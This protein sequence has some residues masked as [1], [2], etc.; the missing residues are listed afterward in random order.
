[1]NPPQDPID[2]DAVAVATTDGTEATR[3]LLHSPIN[4]RSTSLAILALLACLVALHLASAVFIPLLVGMMVSYALSPVVDRLERLHVPRALGAALL[5]GAVCGS[6][7]GVAYAVSDDATALIESLPEVSQKLRQTVQAQR[8]HSESAID[9]MQRA[10]TQLEQA[11]RESA[12]ASEPASAPRGVTRVTIER[13]HFDIKD[14]L[15][16]GTLG[17]AASVGQAVVVVFI[18]FFLM[19]SGNTFRRKIVH[20]AGPT[21]AQ[22]RITVEVLDEITAQIHRYLLVQ[23]VTSGFVGLSVGLAFWA[24]GLER[25]AV[26]GVVALVFDFVPYFGALATTLGAGLVAFVQFG[27]LHM[28][29][30]VAGTAMAIHTLSGNLLMPWLTSQTSRMNAV[31]VFVGVLAFGWLWG[32]WG[33]L[34]GVP[35]LAAVKAICDRVEGL[36][37]IGE[38]MGA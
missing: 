37:P 27:N 4:V 31:T 1:M 13:P 10:A 36:K 2:L 26:W 29:L 6:V 15:W 18:A 17:V 32:V 11:A 20:I 30:L 3:S 7:G 35:V 24:I 34:L 5:L 38:L 12:P 9:K 28:A 14:Y 33:L 23:L 8:G 21:F 25:A 22:R 16:S 19:S